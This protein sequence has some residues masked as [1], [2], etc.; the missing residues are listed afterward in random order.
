M[1]S[2]KYITKTCS[3]DFSKV[4]IGILVIDFQGNIL[5][6][7]DMFQ[8]LLNK[9]HFN[10]RRH[11]TLYNLRFQSYD[12]SNLSENVAMWQSYVDNPKTSLRWAPTALYGVTRIRAA[13]FQQKSIGRSAA[14]CPHRKVSLPFQI[15]MNSFSKF[16][17]LIIDQ[18]GFFTERNP[19]PKYKNKSKHRR[20]LFRKAIMAILFIN[21]LKH[22]ANKNR[23]VSTKI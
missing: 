1:F 15:R 7:S 8:N 9:F 6:S 18:Q 20:Q 19:E 5:M 22:R 10:V 3:L 11:S 14:R 4:R 23:S 17:F 21:A 16:Y 2:W 12:Q 13:R